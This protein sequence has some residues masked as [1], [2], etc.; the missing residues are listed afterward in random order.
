MLVDTHC[1]VHF[2]G[3]G[4]EK[5]DV[6]RR[7]DEAGVLMLTVGT[8]LETSR[9]ALACAETHEG[10]W[11]S[12]GLHPNHTTPSPHHDEAELEH[13]PPSE[14]ERFDATAFRELVNHPKCVAI[15]ECGLDF[16]RMEGDATG[17]MKKQD[18]AV[19]AQ[20]DLATQAGKPVI[21]HCRDAHTEQLALIR[22]Y[23]D[24]GKLARRGVIHCFT[25]TLEEAQAYIKLGFLI[26]FT[27]IITF[28]PRKGEGDLSSLQRV[29]RE[30]PL[31]SILIETD[32]P[33][34]TPVPFRG[35]RNEPGHVKFVAEKVSE[36]KRVAFD[37]V[38]RQTTENAKCL[39]GLK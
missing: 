1:H 21:I 26:S 12:I 10:V 20:F 16:Y 38:A 33:Y 19:R 39:F 13:A 9:D 17:E 3:Y 31:A 36:L 23:V 8:N 25:G 37:D 32:S 27:G 30:L 24:A 34:L 4:T 14:G 29:V 35:K 5:E 6:I 11:A 22:E 7:A 28:P 15:G 2:R 18:E